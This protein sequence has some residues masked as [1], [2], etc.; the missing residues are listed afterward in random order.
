MHVVADRNAERMPLAV[1][2]VSLQLVAPLILNI[3]FLA[4]FID[5]LQLPGAIL[6]SEGRIHLL[7]PRLVANLNLGVALVGGDR[8]SCDTLLGANRE[9]NRLSFMY[10]LGSL[11]VVLVEIFLIFNVSRHSLPPLCLFRLF[12][13]EVGYEFVI[14]V[15]IEPGGKTFRG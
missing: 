15:G 4:I 3:S 2:V 13:H 5:L 7:V 1:V 10:Q 12:D 11:L 14:I 8:V 6:G 9:V